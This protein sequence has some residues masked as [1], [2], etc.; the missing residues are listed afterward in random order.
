MD[1]VAREVDSDKLRDVIIDVYNSTCSERTVRQKYN[2]S[3][4]LVRNG[5]EELSNFQLHRT[6]NTRNAQSEESQTYQ[7]Y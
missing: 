6:L 3:S 7:M 4:R 5:I 1:L 2:L